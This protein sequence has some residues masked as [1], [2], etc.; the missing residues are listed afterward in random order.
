MNFWW[1]RNKTDSY[2]LLILD[3]NLFQAY[4]V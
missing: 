3:N 1:R 4:L 2:R